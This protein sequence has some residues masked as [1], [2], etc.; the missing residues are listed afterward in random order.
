MEKLRILIYSSDSSGLGY[1]SRAVW[2]ASHIAE[3][4]ENTSMLLLTDLPIANRLKFPEHVDYIHLPGILSKNDET[5]VTRRLNIDLQHTM[6]LRHKITKSTIKTFKPRLIIIESDPAVLPREMKNTF[7]FVKKRFPETKIIWGMPDTVGEPEK[8]IRRWKE[9]DVYTILDQV[10]DEIWV[11]G[12]KSIFD[13]ATEYQLPKT[14]ANRVIYTGYIR[15]PYVTRHR[16]HKDKTKLRLKKPFVLVTAGSGNNG[17]AL[18][19]NYLRFLEHS[20]E[21]LPFRSVIVTGPMMKSQEKHILLDR[22]ENLPNVIFHR[23]SKH[24]L[25][26]L[27][28]AQLVVCHGGFNL[29]CEILTYRKNAIFVPNLS[30]TNEYLYRSQLFKTLGLVELILPNKL[31]P[32]IIGEKVASAFSKEFNSELFDSVDISQDGLRNIIERVKF[33]N[34]KVAFEIRHTAAKASLS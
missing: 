28:Y 8:I 31:S 20:G 29:L 7:G 34:S 10:C 11:H 18:I 12:A 33:L 27:K 5:Y 1:T 19:D 21:A 3:H 22:A 32:D 17:F 24:I 13:F 16:I 30:A 9:K 15:A 4:I 6:M 14:L 2:I 26:Y 25:Q 23:Y